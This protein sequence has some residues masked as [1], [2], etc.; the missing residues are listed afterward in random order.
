[1]SVPAASENGVELFI[2]HEL[3]VAAQHQGVELPEGGR[4]RLRVVKLAGD[5]SPHRRTLPWIG[6]VHSGKGDLGSRTKDIVR[7]EMGSRSE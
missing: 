2:S 6:K 3:V 5:E 4:V 1:V 7:E